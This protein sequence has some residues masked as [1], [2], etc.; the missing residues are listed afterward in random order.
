MGTWILYIESPRI[1]LSTSSAAP[2][3]E[4]RSAK[5][6]KPTKALRKTQAFQ[7]GNIIFTPANNG[8]KNPLPPL[9][10]TS[11]RLREFYESIP[12][13]ILDLLGDF[14]KHWVMSLWLVVEPTHLKNRI[15]KTG[16]FPNFRDEHKKS[17]SCHHPGYKWRYEF[18]ASFQSPKIHG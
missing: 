1:F 12:N 3:K 2:T 6:I 7:G 11:W 8:V 5:G 15:I 14:Y 10:V 18:W 4:M 13:L 17:L 9:P 16:I